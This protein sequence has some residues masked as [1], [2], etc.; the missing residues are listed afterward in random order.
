MLDSMTA[1]PMSSEPMSDFERAVPLM[2]VAFY[3][4]LAVFTWTLPVSENKI[5]RIQIESPVQ[6]EMR[7]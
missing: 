4:A 7:K 5:Q 1:T 6:V 2:F 3:L